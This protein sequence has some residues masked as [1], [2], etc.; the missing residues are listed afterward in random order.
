MQDFTVPNENKL[1]LLH[2]DA[3]SQDTL[4][5]IGSCYEFKWL[6]DFEE[7]VRG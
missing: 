6:S 5:R 4:L 7:L 3:L 1:K 2:R